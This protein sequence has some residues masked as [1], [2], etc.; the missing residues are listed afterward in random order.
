[1]SVNRENIEKEKDEFNVG[2]VSDSYESV[3]A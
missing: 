2:P 1:M 3:L